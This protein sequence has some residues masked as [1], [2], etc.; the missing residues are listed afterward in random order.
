MRSAALQALHRAGEEQGAAFPAE[1]NGA[2][3]PPLVVEETQSCLGY[4]SKRAE[5]GCC[6]SVC[7]VNPKG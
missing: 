3:E 1:L 4:V 5:L 7:P 6:R 2:L